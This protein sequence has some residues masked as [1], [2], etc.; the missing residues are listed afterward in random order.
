MFPVRDS[1]PTRTVPVVTRAVILINVVVFFFE[2]T[3]PPEALERFFF[4]FGIVPTRLTHPDWAAAKGFPGG[5]YWTLLTHQFLHGGWLHIISNMWAL[6]I[7]G[8]NVEDTMGR[9]RF[10]IFYVT[11]GVLAGLTQVLTQPDSTLPCIGA[12]GAIAG[13]LGAY[14]IFYPTARMVVLLP[15]FFV[16]FF[17][18]VPAVLYLGIWF[19]TQLFNGTLALAAPE[20]AGG[21]AFSAHVGGFVAGMLLCSLFAQ[22]KRRPLQDDEYGLEWAWRR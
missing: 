7:F 17:F 9:V 19:A 20:Q 2:L 22:R 12:S 14:L 18:E 4:L 11:C 1:I 8:D 15:I 3:L 21:I 13:V 16:P 5:A 6:W 10:P